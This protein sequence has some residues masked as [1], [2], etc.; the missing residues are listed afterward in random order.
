[1]ICLALSVLLT[2]NGRAESPS[3]PTDESPAIQIEESVPAFSLETLFHPKQRHQYV[4][5]RAPALR[6]LELDSKSV[7]LIKRD[8]QWQER[9]LTTGEERPTEIVSDLAK[10][11]ETLDSID[12]K[13][14]AELASQWLADG[15]R[16]LKNV[17]VPIDNSLALFPAEG[18]PRWVTR[19]L[20]DWREWTLSPDAKRIA[21]VQSKDLYVQEIETGEQ[22]RV[23]ADGSETRLNGQLDWV[24]QEEVF[25]R[26]NY[27]AI[28]WSPDSSA[29][30]FLRFDIAAEPV[31]TLGD[32]RAKQGY[33][34][35]Q[36]YPYAGDPMPFV[37]LW[38]AE[39]MP[40]AAPENGSSRIQLKPIYQ[41]AA[42]AERLLTR[43]GWNHD[44]SAI[45]LQ[46]SNRVQNQFVLEAF[47][48]QS[49]T[50]R[51]T[52]VEES[53]SRWLEVQELPR[54]LADGSYLRLSDLPTGRRRLWKLSNDGSQRIPLTPDDFDV[55]ELLSVDEP[56]DC[57]YIAGDKERGNAGQQIY[58]VTLS[59]QAALQPVTSGEPW[60]QVSFSPDRHWML[61][62]CSSIDKPTE[63]WLRPVS[64]DSSTTDNSGAAD[65]YPV[66]LYREQ[67]KL[68]EEPL[69]VQWLSIPAED[70][71]P[72]RA[73]VIRPEGEKLPVLL[74]F[75]GGPLAPNVRDQ[76]SSSKFFM[77][78][79]LARQGVAVMSVETRSGG[80]RGLLDTWNIHRRMGELETKDLESIAAWLGEQPWAD[81][82]QIT[83]RGWSF[84]G[85]LTLHALTHSDRFAAGIAGG[86]VTDWHGYDS[87]Y[88][89]RYMGLPKDNPEGYK[90]TSPILAAGNLHGRLL[91]LHGEIDD[92]V[93][94]SNTMLM[95]NALQAAGKPFQ[96]MIYPGS[97]H[98]IHDPMQNYHLMQTTMRFLLQKD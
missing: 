25:G 35:H 87:I 31:V 59:E 71:Q 69:P 6:W 18:D 7:L 81:A 33:W 98:G 88:T 43:V 94:L 32:S 76:W 13:R 52:L 39:I 91:M 50:T 86:S 77:H 34:M 61:D 92:N 10:R 27:R 78:Q 95:A 3:E 29:I 93:H 41:P 89:E 55:R 58:R 22:F 26:G 16:P 97:M 5:S 45:W 48:R 47:Q 17:L 67:V 72:L 44:S 90:M 46:H 20:N 28:W 80:G 68:H 1:M 66:R 11:I 4:V 96:L 23:T 36:R 12:G 49:P 37:E 85:F 15:S 60:H 63:I 56:A 21:Y 53:C 74:E 42:S 82:D 75:Y 8:K 51:S 38:C 73:T 9:D 79:M 40:A 54:R 14:A 24:Y 62:R 84:G 70:G 30:A 64:T 19:S 83:L 57:V 2:I 65:G